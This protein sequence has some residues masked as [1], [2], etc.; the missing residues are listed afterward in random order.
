MIEQA[1]ISYGP[2][3]LWTISNLAII[4]FFLKKINSVIEKN[5]EAVILLKEAVNSSIKNDRRR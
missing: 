1:L 5:T 2:F 3:G 4:W